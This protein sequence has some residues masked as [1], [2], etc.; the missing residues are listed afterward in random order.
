M[1]EEAWRGRER[2]LFVSRDDA[3][4]SRGRHQTSMVIEDRREEESTLSKPY[5]PLAISLL[6]SPGSTGM[7]QESSK[8]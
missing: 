4:P 7:T 5:I 1:A 6:F 3:E 8:R 2:F